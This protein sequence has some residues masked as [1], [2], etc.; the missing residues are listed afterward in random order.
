MKFIDELDIER[1]NQTLNFETNDC[2]ISGGCDIFTTK[3]VA[4]DRKLYK[5]IEDH[6]D[7]LLK[8]NEQFNSLHSKDPRDS[9]E[10]SPVE[11][12]DSTEEAANINSFWVQKRRISVSTDHHHHMHHNQVSNKLNQQ[13]LK[14]L[15]DN[16]SQS[17]PQR[18]T[19]NGDQAYLSSSSGETSTKQV[20]NKSTPTDKK[21][22]KK[23]QN[24]KTRRHSSLND[25]PPNISLGPFG[26]I[27]EASSRKT[28]AYLIAILNAS[29][30]DHDFS[31]IEPTDFIQSN[32]ITL[33]SKFENSLISMGN[34]TTIQQQLN[35]NINMWEILNNHMDLNDCLI[36]NYNPKE[37]S[38]LDDEPGNLWNQFWFLFNKKR[39]RVLFLYLICSRIN[40]DLHSNNPSSSSLFP[41]HS[42]NFRALKND[43]EGLLI[44]DD[45]NRRKDLYEGEY[46]LTTEDANDFAIADDD[47]DVD[48]DDDDSDFDP[49]NN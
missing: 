23:K 36:Y 18:N 11:S 38:F 10:T 20:N 37:K 40:R 29:Y 44:L 7:V 1:L 26:P 34:N 35:N 45:H 15:I 12:K 13:N 5:T 48:I 33:K 21:V 46:D 8:E 42:N 41:F 19:S 17:K 39:K 47:I 32:L 22:S 4:S 28:F 14:E 3:A 25:A 9:K 24:Q 2:I 6:L 27:N 16:T 43:A 49:L 31:L 30:P